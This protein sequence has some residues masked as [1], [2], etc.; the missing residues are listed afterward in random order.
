MLK[1]WRGKTLEEDIPEGDSSESDEKIYSG[2]ERDCESS[3]D[4]EALVV[5]DQPKACSRSSQMT[6]SEGRTLEKLLKHV[7][8]L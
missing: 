5:D 8:L 1:R 6:K 3:E 4:V 2:L 7:S